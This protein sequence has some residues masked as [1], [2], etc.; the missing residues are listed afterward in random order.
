M[1]CSLHQ[2]AEVTSITKTF[3]CRCGLQ[4]YM[5]DVF[6][7]PVDG[8]VYEHISSDGIHGKQ[9]KR[10][11]CDPFSF[12]EKLDFVFCVFIIE[13]LAS[14]WKRNISYAFVCTFVWSRVCTIQHYSLFCNILLNWTHPNGWQCKVT[15]V[16][17]KGKGPSMFSSRSMVERTHLLFER[18]RTA[19]WGRWSENCIN[20]FDLKK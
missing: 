16:T 12:D 4:A 6:H 18:M 14:V 11:Y 10:F 2:G 9:T 8:P 15:C 17:L 3:W 5:V 13:H 20:I 1:S 19:S 7:L